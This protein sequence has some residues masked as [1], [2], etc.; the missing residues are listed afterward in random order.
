[1]KRI[2]VSALGFLLVFSYS[3]STFAETSVPSA[4]ELA[5]PILAPQTELPLVPMTD[6][7]TPEEQRVAEIEAIA[8]VNVTSVEK[9]Q[10][11]VS[12][13]TFAL[14]TAYNRADI[15][16]TFTFLL[17][18]QTAAGL[19]RGDTAY[20]LLK[21][22][23]QSGA[24]VLDGA[25]PNRVVVRGAEYDEIARALE[26]TNFFSA[27]SSDDVKSAVARAFVNELPGKLYDEAAKT[28]PGFYAGAYVDDT[29]AVVLI[30]TGEDMTQAQ[31]QIK[32]VSPGTY[33]T[34]RAKYSYNDLQKTL[35]SLYV[36]KE[37]H[38]ASL[39][40]YGW[41]IDDRS[42]R[43]EVLIPEL[44]KNKEAHFRE[45]ILDSPMLRFMDSPIHS[46]FSGSL[47]EAVNSYPYFI[48]HPEAYAG[49]YM[50]ED[51]KTL[52]LLLTKAADEAMVKADL[53][54]LGVTNHEIL[55]VDHPS[56]AELNRVSSQISAKNEAFTQEQ[57]YALPLA[58]WG[59]DQM[60]G[61]I[62]VGIVRLDAEKE[63]LFKQWIID[64]PHVRLEYMEDFVR[65][66][67]Q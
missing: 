34:K 64:S 15:G 4:P 22:D 37:E 39:Q 33:K 49:M 8:L 67:F 62:T 58:M 14:Q 66:G 32:T 56:L 55:I 35:K 28:Y 27:Y 40:N 42:N 57:R 10:D 36:W 9:A 20:L 52:V 48:E 12:R 38:P 3:L 51:Q 18:E 65:T 21:Q 26:N 5:T 19:K 23:T 50:K 7:L 61:V 2:F 43:V 25:Q 6:E 29:D 16:W 59:V 46:V 24:W 47:A 45:V 54:A 11:G 63:K 41:R 31:L 53:E 17:S 30:A 13:Y 60:N 44:T 1:M